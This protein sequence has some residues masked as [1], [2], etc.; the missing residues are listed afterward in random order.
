MKVMHI[1]FIAHI[2][3]VMLTCF[4]YGEYS[5][6]KFTIPTIWLWVLFLFFGDKK[7]DKTK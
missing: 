7:I 6:I 1:F 5:S 2:I 3:G 4:W